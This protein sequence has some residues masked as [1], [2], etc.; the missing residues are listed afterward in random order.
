MKRPLRFSMS[1]SILFL[2]PMSAIV[3]AAVDIPLSLSS[4]KNY[5]VEVVLP[6]GSTSANIED[7]RITAEG[8]SQALATVVYYDGLGRPEQT[9]RVGFTATGADLLSTVGYD[10]A[11]REYRQ[12][13]PTPVSGNNGCYVNPSTYGQTAQSYYGDTYLYRETL[14][15]NSPLSRTVGV[16]NPGSVWNAHPKTAAYRCNTAE[17]VVLFRI[18]SD[19]VQRVGRYTPGALYVTR[20]TDEDGIWQESFTDKSG[21]VVMTRQGNGY[22]TYYIYDDHGRLCYVLPPMAVDGMHNTGNYPDSHTLLQQYA[23]LYK[24]DDRGNCIGKRLPGCKSIQ[25][26]YDRANRLVMSQDGNQQSGSLWTITKYDAL[27]RVLYTYEAN[28]LRSPGDLRQYCKEKL[29]VEERADSYTAWP[30]MGYTLRILLPAAND[31][32]LLTV[33]YYDDYSFLYIEG[34]AASQLAYRSK[35]GYGAAYSSAKGLLTGTQVFDLTDRSKYAITV[36][37]Y[38]E[39]G[40][41]VQTRTRH[42]SGD[43]EM[44][45]AQCDLSGNILESYTEHLDSRGRLSVSES[46]ENTYD[47]SGR[48]T[49]TDYTVNDS[50]STDWRYEYDELGRISGKSIDG[51]LTHAKYRYNLQGWITRIEDVDFVQNLYYES[52]MGNYG[53]VRYNGNISAM[54][55]TYRTDTDTIV[56]GY[57]FTYDAHDRLASAYSVT[58]SDFSSGRYHVEYEY[59]KHG[60]MVNLYRNGG[61]GGMIDEMNWSYEGNRVVEITDMV[62]EQG[63]YDMKEYRDYNHNGLDYFYDSNGN[64]TADLDRD[65]VAIRYNLLNQPDTVQFRNGSA[66]VNYYTAD[67]KR[68]GSKYLTPLTTVVIPAGQTFGSTSGTAAMSSHVTARR[69]SLEY[70]GADFESDTLIRIHNGD[71]YLD[72]SEQDF[73]YFVRDYQGNIRTVYGSALK[74][75]KF[76]EI[77]K[78]PRHLATVPFDWFDRGDMQYIELQKTVTYQRMQYYPFG[79]PYEAHYQPEEQPYKYGGKEFIELH[80]YDSYDFDARMYYPALCRFMT[81]DLLCEKYY[82]ISPYAYCNNNP[83]NYVDPDGRDWYIDDTN[84]ILYDP[85]LSEKTKHKLLQ[86]GQRYL[87]ATYQSKDRQGNVT[88]NY[89]KDGSII[90]TNEKDAYNRIVNNSEQTGNEEMGIIMNNGILVLPS[91]KN[92]PT[93]IDMKDYGYSIK[94]GIVTNSMGETFNSIATIHTHPNGSGPSTYDFDNFG[95][96]GLAQNTPYKP[97]YVLQLKDKYEVS[98][99]IAAPNASKS[100]AYMKFFLT[101]EYS[102]A[103]IHNLKNGRFSLIQY[104]NSNNFRKAFK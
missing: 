38:D 4:E 8:A 49:R 99:I 102:Y 52:L 56:N 18:S 43:Y 50:L 104:T 78:P 74:N 67:G 32:R 54:N 2:S 14:Y 85:E 16:K 61:K 84:A 35:E 20:E 5:I 11:G 7:G 97:V 80:G 89:R 22:D 87:G 37:Y 28:P 65:I 24:Y 96:L 42:V 69:G 98:F 31:Y 82:S 25:L 10:E 34:T 83:V 90:F 100:G 70:A 9:A 21:R 81:M 3:S 103:N 51:G 13:L 55:W 30:G 6:G 62:G 93:E 73:R 26:I 92:S 44:T 23:Y 12:G 101:Q 76:I 59:D 53:K 79:L 48:L 72:C 71:G 33:N 19:G 64:M 88:T 66:I 77:D 46:V 86:E 27:S 36:Y 45:Y 95:D 58:G 17:E 57:R 40:N 75:L 68:T 41:P 1:L 60:N 94:D 15:E 39:Y 63:R 47:R 29:F 91:Y